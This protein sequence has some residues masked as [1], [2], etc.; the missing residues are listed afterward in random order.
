MLRKKQDFSRTERYTVRRQKY[1]LFRANTKQEE[2]NI[3]SEIFFKYPNLSILVFM[4]PRVISIAV[5]GRNYNGS[6]ISLFK[7]Q[8]RREPWY[9]LINIHN[10]TKN[11]SSAL[12]NLHPSHRGTTTLRLYF[13]VDEVL[14][15]VSPLRSTP[16]SPKSAFP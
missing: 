13:H 7:N 4:T 15:A 12:P 16:Q 11:K 8:K 10:L 6:R 2:G 9:F 5:H 3:I 1:N 14:P